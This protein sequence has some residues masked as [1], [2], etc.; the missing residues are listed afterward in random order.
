MFLEAATFFFNKRVEH[1]LWGWS[2]SYTCAEF[3]E[4]VT[5]EGSFHA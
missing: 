2:T 4:E 3:I 5:S 1:V